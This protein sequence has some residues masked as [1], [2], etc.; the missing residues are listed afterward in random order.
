MQPNRFQPVEQKI[1]SWG[2]YAGM[3]FMDV[4]TN[5]LKWFASHGY[6]QMKNRKAWSIKELSR[7]GIEISQNY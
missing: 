3:R 1:I 5:Y 6:K 2:K 7:R 4:P